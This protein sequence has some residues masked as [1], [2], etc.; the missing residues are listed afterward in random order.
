M[1]ELIR[2]PRESAIERTFT[3]KVAKAGGRAIKFVSPGLRGV[4]DRIV[5]K[6]GGVVVFVE[7]KKKGEIPEPLQLKRREE[8]E[9]LG[10]R[11]YTIDSL[12]AIEEFIYFE[13]EVEQFKKDEEYY[14]SLL[15]KAGVNVEFLP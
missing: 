3:K 14:G 8:F 4:M 9:A 7:L 5:L 2:S 11:V 6:P 10:F 13:F 15:K 12:T 1:T